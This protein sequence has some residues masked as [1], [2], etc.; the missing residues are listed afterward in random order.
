[1]HLLGRYNR[2]LLVEYQDVGYVV[3]SFFG[4]K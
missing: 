2:V 3:F 1:M 4:P